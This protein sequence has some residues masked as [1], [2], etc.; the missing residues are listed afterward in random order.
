[1][2]TAFALLSSL[3]APQQ[4]KKTNIGK[5]KADQRRAKALVGGCEIL[6]MYVNVL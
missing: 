3:C 1:M 4:T 2:F 6:Y 5:Q